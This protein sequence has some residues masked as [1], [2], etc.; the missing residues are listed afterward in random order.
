MHTEILSEKQNEVLNL[1]KTFNKDFYLAGGT[2]IALHLGHRKS[3]DFDL[4]SRNELGIRAIENQIN[5]TGFAI[6][7]TFISTI[8]EYTVII[9][10]V[11][12]SFVSF[13]FPIMPDENLEHVIKVPN[14]LVLAGMKAYALGRRAKW[15]DYVDLYF[16]IRDHFSVALIA[17]EAK[18]IFGG[19][20]NSRSFREQLIWFEGIDYSEKI[21]Y[22]PGFEISD[23]EIKTFLEKSNK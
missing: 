2:S 22:M 21:E 18:K 13:P 14:L 17:D 19:S 23:D 9:N 5:R 8:D 16:V 4:F 3:I 20:F 11:K 15:K 1:L 7:Q 10:G 6:E 12:V